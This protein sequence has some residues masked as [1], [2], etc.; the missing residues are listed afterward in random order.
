MFFQR[1]ERSEMNILVT[2]ANGQLGQEI[3]KLL[4]EH[5]IN[6]VALNSQQLDITKIGDVVRMVNDTKPDVII[7]AAAYTAVDNAEDDGRELNWEVNATAVRNLSEVAKVNQIKLVH[8]ST[9]YVFEGNSL[10][11]YLETDIVNPQNEYG[12]AKLAGEFAFLNS[13]VQGY[14]VRT[15]WVYG[16]FGKN[17]VYTMR[18][19]AERMPELKVVDDQIGRPTWTR[20]LAEFILYLIESNSE[21]GIYNL[22]DSGETTSWFGF[23]KEILANKDIKLI[24]VTSS[25]FPTKASRPKFSA[26]NLDKSKATGF[27][28]PTWQESLKTFLKNV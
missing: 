24:P 23:A 25:D 27:A 11:E 8:V 6:F 28:I 10:N 21:F 7:N 3:T 20:T 16:E 2:G 19:L 26:F 12:R 17:F 5:G 18:S 9:D 14:I 13:G 15:S 1:K 22:S 4:N